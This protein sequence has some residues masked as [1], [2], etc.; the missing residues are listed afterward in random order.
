MLVVSVLIKDLVKISVSVSQ[1]IVTTQCRGM[2][3]AVRLAAWS[4]VVTESSA[5]QRDSQLRHIA[6]RLSSGVREREVEVSMIPE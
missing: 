1:L 3:Q 2:Q 5:H 6:Y 4:L